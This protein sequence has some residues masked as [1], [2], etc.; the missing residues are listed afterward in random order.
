MLH[1]LLCDTLVAAYFDL[2][3]A[4]YFLFL[5]LELIALMKKLHEAFIALAAQLQQVNEA[6]KVCIDC[7]Q[8]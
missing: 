1:T 2:C 8:F 5:F 3:N 7:H 4:S 6:V